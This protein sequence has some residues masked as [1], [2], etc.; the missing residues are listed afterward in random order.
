M[1]IKKIH[2]DKFRSIYKCDI[3]LKDITAVVGE[4]NSGKTTIL[5]A[6][7]AFFNFDE[8]ERFF[9]DNTHRFMPRANTRIEIVFEEVPDGDYYT[10]KVEGN[11]FTVGITY[12][13]SSKKRTIYYMKNGV[14]ENADEDL[15]KEIKKDIDYLYVPAS[16]GNYDLSWNEN[17]IFS[18]LVTEFARKY[19]ESRD[20]VSNHVLNASQ[21]LHASI[22]DKIEN[23][24]SELFP[25]NESYK[26]N[27]NYKSNVDYSILLDN[28][29]LNM[30]E[31]EVLYP[32]QEYGSGIKSLVIITIFRMLAAMS[33]K[34]VILGIEEPET[35]LHP[36]MQKQFIASMKEGKRENEVQ[37]LLATHSTVIVD[38]LKHDDII[39]VR[40]EHHEKRGYISAVTQIKEGF[41]ER[42]DMEEFNYYQF[43]DYRNSDF[44]FA[45][46]V[47]I[48]ESKTDTQ[49]IG[50]L[51]SKELGW[52]MS[53][54]SL[55]NLNGITSLAYPYFLL[56]E[57][58]IPFSVVVDR[59]FFTEYKEDSLD[60]SRDSITGL[61]EYKTVLNE[62][63]ILRDFLQTTN[64][65]EA[66]LN[67]LNGKVYKRIFDVLKPYKFYTMMYC[68]DMDMTCSGRICSEYYSYMNMLPAEQTQKNLLIGKKKAIK[69][70]DYIL[71]ALENVSAHS[72]PI[73]LKKIKRGIL[74]DISEY[75]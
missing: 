43:F 4:N 27:I 25:S 57:L 21:K 33:N 42:A 3:N 24:L 62:T 18:I 66:V 58:K 74:D 52:K 19:T 41:W 35:N 26:F 70:I 53:Y 51:I 38:E 12:K 56:K 28:L 14:E 11:L 31:K 68:L 46:Y 16:R 32:I 63:N 39:L 9:I 59:D 30:Q 65:K 45:K 23:Q 61:P 69:R 1:K 10:D 20:M 17:S 48:T 36:Q 8:E 34:S 15:L 2:I 75:V 50:K 47:V 73:S 5:R 72:Y 13:Y 44:F 7:N 71:K 22:L 60:E 67:A 40:R 55:I 64:Q 6:L 54:V 49:V 37:L 29:V